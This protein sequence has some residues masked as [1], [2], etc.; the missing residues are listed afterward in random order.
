MTDSDALSKINPNDIESISV[1]KDAAAVAIYGEKAKNGVI[2][3]KMKKKTSY[4]PKMTI[5]G[6]DG[7]MSILADTIRAK[8]DG[9]SV[10]ITADKL[11]EH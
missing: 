8:V 11:A 2:L 5:Y 4:M 10:V 1:L 3:I 7:P 6:K 9:Q